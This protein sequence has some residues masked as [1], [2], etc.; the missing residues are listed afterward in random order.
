MTVSCGIGQRRE[1]W[2]SG[3]T[4]TSA[5]IRFNFLGRLRSNHQSNKNGLRAGGKM[6]CWIT[7]EDHCQSVCGFRSE[8][9][10]NSCSGCWSASSR[11]ISSVKLPIPSNLPGISKRVLMAIFKVAQKQF[12][13]SCIR[14]LLPCNCAP[15]GD[16]KWAMQRLSHLPYQ[17]NICHVGLRLL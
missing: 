11:K 16:A 12:F 14:R 6:Q 9:K 2:P 15:N 13:Q 4:K 10:W 17:A 5:L 1:A 7:L 8:I 3:E